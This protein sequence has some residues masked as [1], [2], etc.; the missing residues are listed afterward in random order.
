MTS[1]MIELPEQLTRVHND[2]DGGSCWACAEEERQ[3]SMPPTTTPTAAD[4]LRERQIWQCIARGIMDEWPNGG[5]KRTIGQ[6]IDDMID[7][8]KVVLKEQGMSLSQAPTLPVPVKEIEA[9]LSKRPQFLFDELFIDDSDDSEHIAINVRDHVGQDFR[10]GCIYGFEK[11]ARFFAE[12]IVALVNA[13]P[14]LRQLHAG[15]WS[16]SQAAQDVL[17]ER[18]RQVEK[19]GWTPEHDDEHSDGALADAAA[20]YA[21]SDRAVALVDDLYLSATN[22]QRLSEHPYE[23]PFDAEWW[24]PKDRRRDLVRAGALI[25][26]EIERLDRAALPDAPTPPREGE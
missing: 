19:E 23:W 15:A 8:A 1:K 12:F 3:K 20:C 4:E 5:K 21:M 2:C 6:T 24:K 17:G 18:Q 9:L 7:T 14:A 13:W 26:A 22:Q 25:L 16:G 11:E 10:L